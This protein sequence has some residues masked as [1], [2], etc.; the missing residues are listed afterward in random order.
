MLQN[1]NFSKWFTVLEK[2][3]PSE[4]PGCDIDGTRPFAFHN[5]GGFGTMVI[6]WS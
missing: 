4:I 1:M 5:F 3:W 2:L 6:V